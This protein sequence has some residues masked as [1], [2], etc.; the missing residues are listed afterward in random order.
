MG[1]E[2][3]AR[4]IARTV[5]RDYELETNVDIRDAAGFPIKVDEAIT[6]A[7]TTALD[8]KD[9]FLTNDLQKKEQR[10]Q[11]VMKDDGIMLEFLRDKAGELDSKLKAAQEVI[12]AAKGF[13]NCWRNPG[14][15]SASGCDCI[16]VL[17]D[18][19]NKEALQDKG[20]G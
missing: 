11:E 5:C 13:M 18:A 2:E 10:L 14:G 19:L 3:I 20:E 12:A 17:S 15:C 9:K 6:M 8:N 16:G 4:K 7:I 1:N